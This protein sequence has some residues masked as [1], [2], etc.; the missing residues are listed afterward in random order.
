MRDLA[1]PPSHRVQDYTNRR[2]RVRALHATNT[3]ETRLGFAANTTETR[4]GY[5]KYCTRVI[6]IYKGNTGFG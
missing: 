1:L 2:L 5:P 3:T 4:L 6:P